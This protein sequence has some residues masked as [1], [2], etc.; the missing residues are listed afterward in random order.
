MTE[1]GPGSE[2]RQFF[3]PAHRDKF[4]SKYCAN[5]KIFLAGFYQLTTPIKKLKLGEEITAGFAHTHRWAIWPPPG[6]VPG[7][8]Q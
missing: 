6:A 3:P 4:K 7:E 2:T 5:V 1:L 8:A